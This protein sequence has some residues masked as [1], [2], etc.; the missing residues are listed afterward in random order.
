MH[1]R[2]TA[3]SCVW[4]YWSWLE[5]GKKKGG[6]VGVGVAVEVEVRVVDQRHVSPCNANVICISCWDEWH[7]QRSQYGEL[8]GS[9]LAMPRKPPC[10]THCHSTCMQH[11]WQTVQTVKTVETLFDSQD[12]SG[13]EA[14]RL[15]RRRRRRRPIN[16]APRPGTPLRRP[17]LDKVF[18]NQA[19]SFT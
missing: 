17:S 9:L 1:W 19:D 5:Y 14:K 7:S 16:L 18:I 11:T 6:G 8:L 13:A 3:A 2:L 10:R 15:R 4:I 12:G